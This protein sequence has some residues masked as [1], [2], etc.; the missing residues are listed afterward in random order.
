VSVLKMMFGKHAA[1]HYAEAYWPN[2]DGTLNIVEARRGRGK[3][4]GAVRIALEWVKERWADIASGRAPFAKIYTNIKFHVHNFALLLCRAGV[5][6]N[7]QS[8]LDFVN[9]R[10]VYITHW[11]LL[12][13]AFD[14]LCLVDEANRNLNIYDN[15]KVVQTVMLTIHDWLQQTRK[16]LLTLWFFVQDVSWLKGQVL[17]LADRLWRAKRVRKKGTKLVKYFPWYGSDPFSKGKDGPLNRSADF[18]MKFDFDIWVA[19]CYDTL[20]AVE[21][22]KPEASWVSFGAV[23]EHMIEHGLKPRPNVQM[24]D[25]MTW[26]EEREWWAAQVP[27]PVPLPPSGGGGAGVGVGQLAG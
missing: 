13:T 26:V 11:D 4:F 7:L 3:S 8:A 5:A 18:K 14:S 23:S 1:T 6:P 25:R 24:P 17:S 27:A 19:R 2:H 9:A 22:L 12:L 16:H 20:Q 21:T 10:V 15:V